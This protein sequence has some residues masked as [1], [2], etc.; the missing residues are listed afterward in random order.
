MLTTKSHLFEPL[1]GRKSR[2]VITGF[3]KQENCQKG[4]LRK[5]NPSPTKLANLPFE[6]FQLTGSQE[7]FKCRAPLSSGSNSAHKP[8]HESLLLASCLK[9]WASFR[10]V[11]YLLIDCHSAISACY[12]DWSADTFF[13][14]ANYV[15]TSHVASKASQPVQQ[16]LTPTFS[17]P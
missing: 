5:Y 1:Q 11:L 4:T 9:L 17:P 16:V 7:Y 8:S 2:S 3:Q 10:S 14:P 15:V 12:V 13:C 6:R